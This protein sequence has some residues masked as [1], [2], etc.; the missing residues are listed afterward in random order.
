[1]MQLRIKQITDEGLDTGSG[2]VA[3]ADVKPGL[4]FNAFIE[5][6]GDYLI[7][8]VHAGWGN[9]RQGV[10][11]T[12]TPCHYGGIRKWYLC[13]SCRRRCGVLYVGPR[14]ACRSCH[15]LV[16]ASQYE[17][18][19]ERMRRQL[20]KIRKAIGAGMEIEGPFNPPLQGMSA[21]RHRALVE[22]YLTLRAAYWHE[23]EQAR[24]WRGG[25]PKTTDWKLGVRVPSLR[26]NKVLK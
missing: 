5:G 23:C 24:R 16:Y 8:T 11:L 25:A 26:L 15:D 18:P 21:K 19:R 3:I 14:I 13:P 12:E 20:K 10:A 1:M 22:K 9:I 17:A 2:A 4:T 7:I 6:L